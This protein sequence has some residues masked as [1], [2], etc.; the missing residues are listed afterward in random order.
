MKFKLLYFIILPTIVL[1]QEKK[2]SNFVGEIIFNIKT[3]ITDESVF[4][5][6]KNELFTKVD[7][8]INKRDGVSSWTGSNIPNLQLL[9]DPRASNNLV[10]VKLKYH[11]YDTI[12]KIQ[13][14]KFNE[15]T[16]TTKVINTAIETYDLISS[17]NHTILRE[18]LKYNF[19]SNKD[20]KIQVFRDSIKRIQSIDC[21]KV[22]VI[23]KESRSF[24]NINFQDLNHNNYI[25]TEM[26]VTESIQSI[27][28]PLIVDKEILNKFYP[29][30]LK[31]YSDLLKGVEVNL[32]ISYFG[33]ANN[34]KSPQL[35]SDIETQIVSTWVAED[36]TNVKLI[37]DSNGKCLS[38]YNND[39][40][41]TFNYS[42]SHQCD[43]ESD[44]KAWFLKMTDV[45]VSSI[46]CYEL[47]GANADNNNTLTM[48]DMNSGK[49]LV[50]QKQ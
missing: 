5:M 17:K 14:F 46:R 4:N 26:Y 43:S 38:Y 18:N 32:S 47:Y 27:Y 12:I 30:E 48:K 34:Y 20:A 36:D 45:E 2:T 9:F 19:N 21:F 49:L 15:I 37:F 35:Q 10:P 6:S 1:S 28:H 42:I 24:D 11:F 33:L 29:L 3:E 16:K 50:Y 22:L 39:L 7:S 13:A 23:E 40:T 41:S 25:Y 44:L 31:K 8:I